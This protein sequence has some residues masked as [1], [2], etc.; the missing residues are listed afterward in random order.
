MWHISVP[1]LRSTVRS[2]GGRPS[3]SEGVKSQSTIF[4]SIIVLS[5]VFSAAGRTTFCAFVH[6]CD[7]VATHI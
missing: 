6:V 2:G 7:Y 1:A 4:R 5:A 3:E